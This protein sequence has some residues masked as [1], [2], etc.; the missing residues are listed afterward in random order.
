MPPR[1]LFGPTTGEFADTYLGGL[2]RDGSC[3]AFGPTGVDLTVGPETC[4]DDLAAQ[5]PAG[6]RPDLV[7]LWLNYTAVPDCL[8]SAPVPIV[9]LATDWN[10]LWHEYRQILPY[11]DAI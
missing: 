7:T 1:F 5:L 3:L 4:W 2:R 8:W 11:C 6:W 10:L 9:G